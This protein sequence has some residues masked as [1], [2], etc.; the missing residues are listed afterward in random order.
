M[1]VIA[2]AVL[3]ATR[4]A[5]SGAVARA[6]TGFFL[7]GAGR[8]VTAAHLV[9]GCEAV[10]VQPE[11]RAALTAKI[12]SADTALDVAALAVA[13]P[14]PP[15][16]ELMPDLPAAGA[17]LMAIGYPGAASGGGRAVLPLTAIDLPLPRP[18]ERMP[19]RG[20]VAHAGMSGAPVVDE[21]GR[22][23]GMLLG[24]GDPAAPGAAE[25][26]RRIGYPVAEVAIALPAA[27]LP[28]SDQ[29]AVSQ[30]SVARV[31]CRSG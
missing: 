12:L 13:G 10:Q 30:V 19:L 8:L 26:A 7:G 2:L 11:G 4:P 31:L 17:Q 5:E 21:Q 23:I 25:L 28:H 9:A 22:V 1:L 24:R 6:G 16:A 27:W 29:A 18:P 3:T 15:S 14:T 20:E